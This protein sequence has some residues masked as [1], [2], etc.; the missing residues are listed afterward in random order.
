LFCKILVTGATGLIGGALVESL[1][2]SVN[3]I[4]R[5]KG[6]EK[7]GFNYFY[8][9]LSSDADYRAALLDVDIVI[10]CAAR[11]HVMNDELADPL[12][13]YRSVNVEGTLN[14]ARQ[15]SVSGVKRFVFIS[16]A[17]VNGEKTTGVSS[18]NELDTCFPED[19]YAISKIEA[20]HGLLELSKETNMDVVIIRPPL[21]YGPGVK[22]NFLSLMKLA[23]SN[24][25]LP[26]SSLHEKRSLIYLGNLV[27]FIKLCMHHP[28]AAN[29]VFLVSDRSDLSLAELLRI[30]RN[31]MGK[32]SMLF[33]IPK[34]I[35]N[36]IGV[37]SG[38]KELVSRLTEPLQ[39][40][41]NKSYEVLQWQPPHT[42]K[43]G[44]QITVDFFLKEID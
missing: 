41:A 3:V 36:A 37:L 11:A 8:V 32:T 18:F 1:D 13:A 43:E 7:A 44:I 34:F 12:L 28:S 40:D 2:G 9:D 25:P 38:R 22:A 29:Q 5:S 20:E 10:H 27:D 30:M 4:S 24:L 33:P 35:F 15:A 16:S 31:S 39:V 6:E 23:G 19:S 42:V 21:V 26:F 14:L 17:K